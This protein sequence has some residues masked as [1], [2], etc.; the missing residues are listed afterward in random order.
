[1]RGYN[2]SILLSVRPFNRPLGGK[3]MSSPFAKTSASILAPTAAFSST[4]VLAQATG[5]A[6]Q[7]G[8]SNE[9]IVTAQRPDADSPA[10]PTSV[11]SRGRAQFAT[12]HVRPVSAT[13]T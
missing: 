6:D 3:H 2:A 8:A 13:P 1:M 5:T 4:S 7:A 9:I 10:V 11:P 12:P